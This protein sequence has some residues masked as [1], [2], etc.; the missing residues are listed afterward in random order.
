MPTPTVYFFFTGHVYF[1]FKFV[2]DGEYS[3]LVCTFLTS[4][5]SVSVKDVGC[6]LRS[7]AVM[8]WEILCTEFLSIYQKKAC[9]EVQSLILHTVT[10][11]TLS[12]LVITGVHF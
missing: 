10:L 8:T 3:S 2:I 9:Q 5:I 4:D 6:H 7:T 1:Q 12:L 11:I